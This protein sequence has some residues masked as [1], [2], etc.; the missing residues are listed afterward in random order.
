MSSQTAV[1][2]PYYQEE[3]G[4]LREAVVSA[5]S[6]VGVSG[7]E[8]IVVDDGSPVPAR[9]E[10]NGLDLPA[11]ITLKLI[12][13]PNRGPGAARNR[14]LDSV[15]PDTVYVAFLD[16]DDQWTNDHL[17]NAHYIMN[18]GYDLYFADLWFRDY[19]VSFFSR[20]GM[21][22]KLDRCIDPAARLYEFLDDA[23]SDLISSRN[24][25][26]TSSVVYRYDM[27][28]SLRF[29]VEFYMGEDLA[30]WIQLVSRTRRI[31]FRYGIDCVA[32]RGVHIYESQGWGTPKAIWRL[33]E[34][35]KWRK[36]LRSTLLGTPW[37]IE[38]NKKQITKLRRQF[39]LSVLHEARRGRVFSNRDILHF[40]RTDPIALL[41]FGHVPI[42]QILKKAGF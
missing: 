3:P 41:Y 9:A 35:M 29:P 12:E 15:R 6:Q 14:A 13:Q 21:Q 1:V 19:N 18:H 32:G 5:V 39:V 33:H 28:P 22:F 40:F 26:H 11:H 31:V 30:F 37:E 2:V 24:A 7:L 8:I 16:Y 36:W 42:Q 25:F 34:Y 20:Q 38:E 17:R 27:L 23:R 4:I 10:L